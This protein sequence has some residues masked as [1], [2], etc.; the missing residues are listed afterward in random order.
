MERRKR[1]VEMV[2]TSDPPRAKVLRTSSAQSV[3]PPVDGDITPDD[4]LVLQRAQLAALVED[5]RRDLKWMNGKLEEMQQ[6]VAVLD[7]AP[8]AALYHM[9]AVREDLAGT[10]AALGLAGDLGNE[11]SALAARMLDHEVV[12]NESLG[13]AP[14][15]LR[16]LSAKIISALKD[17]TKSDDAD[18]EA[19]KEAYRDLQARFRS[20]SDQLERYAERDK[21]TL[22][23]STTLRDE[24]EDCKSLNA[25]RRNRITALELAVHSNGHDQAVSGLQRSNGNSGPA[26]GDVAGGQEVNST[27]APRSRN[28]PDDEDAGDSKADEKE[29]WEEKALEASQL[30]E[31][32]LQELVEMQDQC[33]D[34]LAKIL[35]LEAQ[36]GKRDS[37]IVPI[38]TVIKS[39]LYQT[40]EATLQQLYLKERKWEQE[41]TSVAEEREEERK[42]A[43]ELL[44]GEKE[45]KQQLS[46]LYTK[47]IEELRRSADAAKAEKDK[48]M[49]TYEARKMESGSL[50]TTKMAY[51]KRLTLGDEVRTNLEAKNAALKEEVEQF[52]AQLT[53]CQDV[54]YANAKQV[55]TYIA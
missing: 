15:A 45:A 37:G 24:L 19:S 51:E 11:Q 2:G 3:G 20:V 29:N 36:I 23:S 14:A 6:L 34:Q 53:K 26:N 33:K 43:Q 55:R 35:R 16:E 30:S 44:E 47:Q 39:A 41:R 42:E 32:R 5:Q 21:Q 10:L 46:D 52:K 8:R 1:D 54:M 38:G 4:V 22:V 9:D 13:D 49:M 31:Q 48:V 40:M 12:T 50:Q 17:G 28:S 18:V 25:M 7:A 27:S